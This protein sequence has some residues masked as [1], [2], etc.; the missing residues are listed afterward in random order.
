MYTQ[1]EQK[2]DEQQWRDRSRGAETTSSRAI[3]SSRESNRESNGERNRKSSIESNYDDRSQQRVQ[4]RPKQTAE[5]I[6]YV[7]AEV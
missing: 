1:Q 4:A 5:L 2:R 7:G 6:E 3:G